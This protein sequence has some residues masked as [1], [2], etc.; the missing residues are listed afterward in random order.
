MSQQNVE[1]VRRIFD[2]WNQGDFD[3]AWAACDSELVIDRSRSLVDSRIYRGT[4]EV[5]QFWSDWRNTWESTRWEIDE[6]IE[7]GDDVVVLGRFF[8][9]GAESG[10]AVEANVTQVMTVRSG[11]LV[12]GVLFQSRSEALEAAGL[13]E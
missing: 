6:Y 4:E 7:A 8:G 2:A 13:R 5:E 11:K 1:I 12:R 10:V 3:A 9:R